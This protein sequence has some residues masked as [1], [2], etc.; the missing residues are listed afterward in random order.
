MIRAHSNV[1]T[2]VH[3][4]QRSSHQYTNGS[5][6]CNSAPVRYTAVH[7]QQY[8]TQ[9]RAKSSTVN[10]NSPTSAVGS[11][12]VHQQQ[13]RT[14]QHANSRRV[15]I[16]AA[17]PVQST[18]AR[19]HRYRTGGPVEASEN[20]DP[21][22]HSMG[23]GAVASTES[24]YYGDPVKHSMMGGA[25]ASTESGYYD[26]P[27]L[28]S[29]RRP[30]LLQNFMDF[31]G[32][33]FDPGSESHMSDDMDGTQLDFSSEFVD[34]RCENYPQQLSSSPGS[35]G[36]IEFDEATARV[37]SEQ[38]VNPLRHSMLGSAPGIAE[39]RQ[40]ADPLVYSMDMHITGRQHNNGSTSHNY[41]PTA[42]H[43]VAHQQQYDSQ[44]RTNSSTSLRGAPTAARHAAAHQ[45]QYRSSPPTPTAMRPIRITS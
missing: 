25:V 32:N 31:E 17:A 26:D 37:Q 43:T 33:D 30:Q 45:Q 1:P 35:P 16:N 27:S 41:A 4:Q 20:N 11:T 18:S 23:G 14:Q 34:F 38:Y 3:Q 44:R 28:S 24:G 21:L 7:Q 42:R 6:T 2:S 5:T 10:T 22:K 12:A 39:E 15:H 40:H 9:Q 8:G 13:Q 19:Q 29:M 36:S